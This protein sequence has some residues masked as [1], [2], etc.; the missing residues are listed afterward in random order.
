MNGHKWMYGRTCDGPTLISDCGHYP[1]DLFGDPWD[2]E[3]LKDHNFIHAAATFWT[4]EARDIIGGWNVDK[5]VVHDW[6]YWMRLG[7]RWRP[8]YTERILAFYRVHSGQA[9]QSLPAAYKL[10]QED[11]IRERARQGY[12]EV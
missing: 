9:I 6:D 1:H 8:L 10:A 12:Y 2:Y 11:L 3:S 4:R 5:D 7:A